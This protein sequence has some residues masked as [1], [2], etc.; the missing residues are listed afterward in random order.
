MT[1]RRLVTLEDHRD[2]GHEIDRYMLTD[3]RPGGRCLTCTGPDALD[4]PCRWA[5]DLVERV[6]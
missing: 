3:D 4:L 5:R 6:S 2:Q 1:G